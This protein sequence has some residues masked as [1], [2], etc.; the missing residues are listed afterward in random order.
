MYHSKITQQF[1]KDLTGLLGPK[2]NRVPWHTLD[3]T[4]RRKRLN[5]IPVYVNTRSLGKHPKLVDIVFFCL[6]KLANM[7]MDN[8]L[9]GIDLPEFDTLDQAAKQLG[10]PGMNYH[11]NSLADRDITYKNA[12]KQR[13]V[14]LRHIFEDIIFRF[15]PG[16]VFPGIGRMNSR[17]MLF[18]ND[19]QHRTLACI[20]LGIEQIPI[21][22]IHS[23]DEYW[24]VAQYAGINIH[25]LPSSEFDR[26]RI[27]VQRYIEA[28]AA[29]MPIEQDDALSYELHELFDN[30]DIIVAEKTDKT[31]GTNSLVLTSIGNM[32]KYRE[33]YKKDFFHRATT[34]NARMFPTC[35]F[36]TANSWG[37]MEFYKYQNS[38]VDP[39]DMD[40]AIM[41][42]LK[43]RWSKDNAGNQL[44]SN[45]K[46]AYKAQTGTS[47]TSSKAPE[48]LIIAHG[49]YQVCKFYD[50]SG[51][52]WVE[53]TWDE[54]TIGPKY[55]LALVH[56]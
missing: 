13:D 55:K 49:I 9:L 21:N 25:S 48:P 32:I 51:I 17:G 5:K 20:I 31:L 26:Y 27:R 15:N 38:K 22:F 34:L 7:G 44:H 35:K 14:F 33:E 24:D 50:K 12:A 47:A 39:I 3:A 2:A 28:L 52:E 18:V 19:A 41:A 1:G 30:L 10:V 6:S 45:M 11:S 23:D 36:H 8:P 53:P 46:D 29:N 37:L 43:T 56:A 40:Y 54:K 42:V 4:E 16:L